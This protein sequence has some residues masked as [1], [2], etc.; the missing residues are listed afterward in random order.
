MRRLLVA[1]AVLVLA[2]VA[3]AAVLVWM[4]VALVLVVG[5]LLA[6]A[7]LSVEHRWVAGLAS[8]EGETR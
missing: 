1:A 2:A 5:G 8:P 4:L 3:L 7:V 6:L